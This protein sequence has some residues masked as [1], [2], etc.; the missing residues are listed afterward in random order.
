MSDDMRTWILN[1]V[2]AEIGD[3]SRSLETDPFVVGYRVGKSHGLAQFGR[4]FGMLSEAEEADIQARA[5]RY[6]TSAAENEA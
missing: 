2:E 5:D 1:E 4:T 6:E 3:G